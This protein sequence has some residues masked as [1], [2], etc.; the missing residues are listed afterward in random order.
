M[1]C[2]RRFPGGALDRLAA[3]CELWVGPAEG[4]P[5]DVLLERCRGAEALICALGDRVDAELLERAPRLRIVATPAAGLDH[6]D[7]AVARERG[8]WVC[9]APEATTEATADLAWALLLAVARRVVEGDRIVREGRFE[10]WSP[11]LLLGQPVAG[12]TLGVVGAGQIGRAV[13]RRA[14]GFGMQLRYTRR[15]GPLESLEAELGA[16]W[17]P[18]ERLLAESD[19]VSL[20]VPLTAQTHH[21]IDARALAS[22]RPDAILVNTSR[23]PVVDEAALAAALAAG[24]P[25]GAGLDVFEAEP[26]VH[27]ELGKSE[28][29]VLSPHAGSATVAARARMIEEA[30]SAVEAVLLDN[31][32]PPGAVVRP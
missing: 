11:T 7:L 1:V 27:P 18:L 2:S 28:R 24:R 10:G 21:L 8:L 23:G 30:V 29:V 13:L 19:F 17:R 12:A 25:R 22:M 20:H 5:R 9:H 26:A 31:K 32:E 15:G 16:S 6:I 3:R 14:V 4:T